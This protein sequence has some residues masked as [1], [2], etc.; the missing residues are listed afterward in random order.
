MILTG[1]VIAIRYNRSFGIE[2]NLGSIIDDILFHPKEVYSG[3]FFEEVERGYDVKKLVSKTT[4]SS[5][6]INIDNIIL[7]YTV[8]KD[9]ELEFEEQITNFNEIIISDIL[10]KYNIQNINRFGCVIKCKYNDGEKYPLFDKV[11]DVIKDG[12]K[13]IDGIAFRYSKTSKK[14]VEKG[15]EVTN[16]YENEI[17]SFE[18]AKPNSNVIFSIDYQKYFAPPIK[19]IQDAKPNFSAFVRSSLTKF[20]ETNS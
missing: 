12:K 15:N 11:Y 2:D 1:F 14:P 7:D 16:D 17:Y 13:S 6:T 4:N 20:K 5:L 19:H 3:K 8:D 9:F 10:K 18:K